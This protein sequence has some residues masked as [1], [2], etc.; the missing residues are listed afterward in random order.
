[1]KKCIKNTTPCIGRDCREL[2]VRGNLE[3]CCREEIR[4]EK[5]TVLGLIDTIDDWSRD[6]ASL[7]KVSC[8]L[9][10]AAHTINKNGEEEL[11]EV[12]PVVK[13]FSLLMHEFQEKILNDKTTGELVRTFTHE[14]QRWFRYRFLKEEHP[15]EHAVAYQSILADMNTIEM[16]LGVCMLFEEFDDSLDE[17]FF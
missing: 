5:E 9:S 17:L 12:L 13:R 7:L 14:L 4:E 15:C 16:G 2:I 10:Y 3:L 1:M 11:I 6:Q 8:R